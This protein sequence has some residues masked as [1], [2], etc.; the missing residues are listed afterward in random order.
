AQKKQ[1]LL[2]Q[3]NAP[4]VEEVPVEPSVNDSSTL[5]SVASDAE[6]TPTPVEVVAETI[7]APTWY[8][9]GEFIAAFMPDA[10]M[11]TGAE[12]VSAFMA[13]QKLQQQG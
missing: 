5:E 3:A 6:S 7:A 9:V 2:L 11:S 12:V 13:A 4:A 10:Q 8:T 1:Q